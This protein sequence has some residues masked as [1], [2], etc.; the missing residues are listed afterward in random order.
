[1]AL[2]LAAIGVYGVLSYFVN[3]RT[4]EMGIRFALEAQRWDVLRL[5]A[6]LGL[7]L[8]GTGSWALCC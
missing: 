1:M 6:K 5:V 8:V 2:T 7:L 3:Q 4:R